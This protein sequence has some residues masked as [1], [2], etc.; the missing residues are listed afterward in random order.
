[1]TN[2]EIDVEEIKTGDT[3]R[4]KSGGPVMTV[5]S[6]GERLGEMT[7]FCSWFDGTRPQTDAFPVTVLVH[8]DPPSPSFRTARVIR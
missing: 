2:R 6:V 8:A 4:V 1:M 7:A 3:V 5:S